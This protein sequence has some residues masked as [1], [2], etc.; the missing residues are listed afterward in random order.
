MHVSVQ[1]QTELNTIAA[2]PNSRLEIVNIGIA[3]ATLVNLNQLVNLGGEN[4]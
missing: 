1:K 4:L 2:Q 3:P